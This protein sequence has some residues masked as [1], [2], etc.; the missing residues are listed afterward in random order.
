[1]VSVILICISMIANDIKHLFIC[2]LVIWI[3]PNHIISPFYIE[4]LVFY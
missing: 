4:L 2:L 3:F 1:M